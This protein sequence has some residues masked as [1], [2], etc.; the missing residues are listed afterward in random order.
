MTEVE[1]IDNLGTIAKSGSKAWLKQI[2]VQATVRLEIE[3]GLGLG[4]TCG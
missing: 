2:Q 1:L 4:W 3:T